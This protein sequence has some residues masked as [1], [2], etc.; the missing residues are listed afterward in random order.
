MIVTHIVYSPDGGDCD[1]CYA[2]GRGCMI[3]GVMN[4]A[5]YVLYCSLSSGRSC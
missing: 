1:G 4:N 3:P 5:F 2:I